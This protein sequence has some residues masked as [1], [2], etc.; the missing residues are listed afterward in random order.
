MQRGHLILSLAALFGVALAA[1]V[2]D[3]ES[4]GDRGTA[5][6]PNKRA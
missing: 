5:A 6:A 2:A 4:N 3:A 1:Y